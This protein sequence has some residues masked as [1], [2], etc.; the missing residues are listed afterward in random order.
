MDFLADTQP[1]RSPLPL[2]SVIALIAAGLSTVIGATG[3]LVALAAFFLG[4]LG[5][6][7]NEAL[8][9]HAIFCSIMALLFALFAGPAINALV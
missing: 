4:G 2:L 1:A 7:R 9:K 8:A 6:S 3:L 5:H